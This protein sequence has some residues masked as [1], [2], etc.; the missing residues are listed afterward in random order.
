MIPGQQVRRRRVAGVV[1]IALIAWIALQIFDGYSLFRQYRAWGRDADARTEPQKPATNFPREVASV[2]DAQREH[3]T[4]WLAEKAA[5]PEDY[6]VE[7]ARQYQVT[8]VGETHG[9]QSYLQLLNRLIPRLYQEAGVRVIAME[10]CPFSRSD[11]L[12]RLVTAE[13]FDEQLARNI[14]RRGAWEA[15]GYR[16]YWDILSADMSSF[17]RP[18]RFPR[19][20]GGRVSSPRACSAGTRPSMRWFAGEN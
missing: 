14:A 10:C 15:W 5:A 9:K 20:P 11:E 6:I 17:C 7:K 8:I 16:E 4:A 3:M 1:S 19:V 12:L 13:T 18:T 2:D